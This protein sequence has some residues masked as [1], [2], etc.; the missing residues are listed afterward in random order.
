M[1]TT[2][3]GTYQNGKIFFNEPPP[4]LDKS[5]VLITFTQPEQSLIKN[6][7]DRK[8]GFAKDYILYVAPDF[9]DSM[10]D[11]FNVFKE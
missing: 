7:I 4:S 8:G 1:F 9:D 5:D 6:N 2:I 3:K 11:L 10:E